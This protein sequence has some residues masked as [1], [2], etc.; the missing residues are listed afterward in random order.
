MP[1][2]KA[3][4]GAQAFTGLENDGELSQIEAAVQTSV[5]APS[6]GAFAQA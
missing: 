3:P 1:R 4:G 5:P 6:A 2:E